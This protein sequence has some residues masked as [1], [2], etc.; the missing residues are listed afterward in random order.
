MSNR[1]GHVKIIFEHRKCF[2][3]V[4]LYF[5][6]SNYVMSCHVMSC[7]VMSCYVM[8]Q[9]AFNV[10]VQYMTE[11]SDAGREEWEQFVSFICQT[12]GDYMKGLA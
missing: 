2:G 4:V 1:T 12:M 8:L 3:R 9:T 7:H 11:K 6:M 5:F 10:L